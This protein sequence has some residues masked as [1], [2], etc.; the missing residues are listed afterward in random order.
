MDTL[1]VSKLLTAALERRSQHRADDIA[2]TKQTLVDS[3]QALG[4]ATKRRD[5]ANSAL[6]EVRQA[7]AAQD[8]PALAQ[9]ESDASADLRL[10]EEALRQ[11]TSAVADAQ[12]AE[13]EAQSHLLALQTLEKKLGFYVHWHRNGV[14][15][16]RGYVAL[17]DQAISLAKAE[18]ADI[19]A[20]E[21]SVQQCTAARDAATKALAQATDADEHMQRAASKS[22]VKAILDAAEAQATARAEATATATLAQAELV[23]AEER[24][25][26][27]MLPLQ[28]L[29]A[30]REAA[31]ALIP[32]AEQ[33]ER[34]EQANQRERDR[35]AAIARQEELSREE[36]RRQAAYDEHPCDCSENYNCH[37]CASRQN[38]PPRWYDNDP[39]R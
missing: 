18:I 8:T 17:V 30:L 35:L 5:D 32:A 12:G 31:N 39:T 19:T 3:R 33:L 38:N 9:A 7:R 24:L 2:R 23:A 37:H 13:Q 21:A 22:K 10:A 14:E 34:I 26:A 25:T 36:A 6:Q 1:R 4:Q 27:A 20:A 28:Y 29:A 11:A 16:A 15:T